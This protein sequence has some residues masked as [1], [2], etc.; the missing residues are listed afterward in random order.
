MGR[1][2]LWPAPVLNRKDCQHWE[3]GA[4]MSGGSEAV[5]TLGAFFGTLLLL[6]W[7]RVIVLGRNS[8]GWVTASNVQLNMR[9]G[10]PNSQGLRR[11][12]SKVPGGGG[13]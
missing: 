8:A 11:M 1:L 9:W 12:K 6:V 2:R 13:S 7:L 3:I 10:R 5:I 4:D